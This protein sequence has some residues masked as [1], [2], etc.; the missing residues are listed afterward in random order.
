MIKK[1]T[2]K[3][4]IDQLTLEKARNSFGE[5]AT[6]VVDSQVTNFDGSALAEDHR[7]ILINDFSYDMKIGS[8]ATRNRYVLVGTI[9]GVGI[10][11]G[12]IILYNHFIKT[13]EEE[14]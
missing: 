1:E 5:L 6:Y 11:T 2:Y 7:E 10:T 3:R 8:M 4:K 13:K 9:L 12:S 14:S